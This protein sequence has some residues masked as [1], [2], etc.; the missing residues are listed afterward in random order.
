MS[1]KSNNKSPYEEKCR[2]RFEMDKGGEDTKT[3]EKHCGR[4]DKRLERCGHK[5]RN[6]DSHEKMKVAKNRL[7]VRN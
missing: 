5:S 4:G 7:S 2:G 6:A 3:R 1:P